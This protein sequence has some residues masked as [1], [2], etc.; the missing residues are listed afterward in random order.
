MD[1]QNTPYK[2]IAELFHPYFLRVQR[3]IRDEAIQLLKDRE[4]GKLRGVEYTHY[5]IINRHK[6]ELKSSDLPSVIKELTQFKVGKN[7]ETPYLSTTI[8]E[9]EGSVF[10]QQEVNI[11]IRWNE[12]SIEPDLKCSLMA[13][14][15]AEN[16][17]WKLK[18]QPDGKDGKAALKLLNELLNSK[19]K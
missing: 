6:K 17:A 11:I 3:E 19:N 9:D 16:A 2:E 4:F 1:I 5:L 18:H 14:Y 15:A 13:R 8:I 10:S 12:I 7:C